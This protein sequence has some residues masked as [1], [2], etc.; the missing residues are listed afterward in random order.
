MIYRVNYSYAAPNGALRSGA[1]LTQ[2]E[3]VEE[4]KAAVRDI[5]VGKL[6]Y[7]NITGATIWEPNQNEL[8]LPQ[9]PKKK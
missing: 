4:A 1:H 3:T 9:A 6:R 5:L 2:A 7:L 8:N